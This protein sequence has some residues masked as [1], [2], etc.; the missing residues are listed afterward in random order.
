MTNS[1]LLDDKKIDYF[2]KNHVGICTSLDGP[3]ELHDENRPFAK[4]ISS[5]EFVEKG[6]RKILEEYKDKNIKNRRVHA[7]ITITKESLKYPREIVDEYIRVGLKDIHLRFLNN[8]GML[9][10]YGEN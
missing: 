10:N 1:I 4:G 3:K 9:D 8:L 6:I 2:I 5:H 7:L